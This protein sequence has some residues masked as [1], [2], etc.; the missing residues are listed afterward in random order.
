MKGVILLNEFVCLGFFVHSRSRIVHSFGD[1]IELFCL[2]SENVIPLIF[3]DNSRRTGR[4]MW[5]VWRLLQRSPT[6]RISQRKIRLHPVPHVHL[7]GG[8]HHQRYS[9]GSRK[10]KWRVLHIQ[11][12]RFGCPRGHPEL[13]RQD[14]A[15]FGQIAWREEDIRSEGERL[16]RHCG[17]SSASGT[18]QLQRV[19][20][21]VDLG[22]K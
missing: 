17:P 12:V 7:S 16:Q 22:H 1:T 20:P 13:F 18:V 3:A 8:F 5:G 4:K 9:P 15:K 11:V 21:A 6:Q 2:M 14:G 19:H 10:R